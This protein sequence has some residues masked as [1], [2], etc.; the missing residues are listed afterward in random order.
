MGGVDKDGRVLAQFI[1]FVATVTELGL[2]WPSMVL[3]LS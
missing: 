2:C 1:I 3:G